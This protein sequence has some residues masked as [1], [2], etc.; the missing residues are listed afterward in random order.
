MGERIR[1]G[2]GSKEKLRAQSSKLKGKTK[3][4]VRRKGAKGREQREVEV[5]RR[6]SWE[7]GKVGG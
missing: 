4:R 1:N 7:G 2:E 3:G 6:R 5:G